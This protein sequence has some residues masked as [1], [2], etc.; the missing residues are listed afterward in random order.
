MKDLNNLIGKSSLLYTR[1]SNGEW[2]VAPLI[3]NNL[4]ISNNIT[5]CN[6][7]STEVRIEA[8]LMNY[9]EANCLLQKAEFDELNPELDWEKCILRGV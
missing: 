7:E 1:G 5:F 9:M 6:D 2:I 3:I 8:C 4:A